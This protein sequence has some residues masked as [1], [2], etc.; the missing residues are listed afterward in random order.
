MFQKLIVQAGVKRIKFHG[1]RH[2]AATLML[3]GGVAPHVA[4]ARLGHRTEM[5]LNVYAHALPDQGQKAAAALA[6]LG[7]RGAS[8][9]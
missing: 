7:A 1:C 6:D 5:L 2:T 3:Q 8:L 9:E 4:A